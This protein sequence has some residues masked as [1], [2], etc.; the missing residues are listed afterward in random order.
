MRTG[1]RPESPSTSPPARWRWP[2]GGMYSSPRRCS[3]ALH[4]AREIASRE[5][6]SDKSPAST[7]DR[8][9]RKYQRIAAQARRVRCAANQS[10]DDS[11]STSWAGEL[12]KREPPDGRPRQAQ[13]PEQ[14]AGRRNRSEE[15]TSELQ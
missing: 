1:N 12:R 5:A 15:H 3:G 2:A 4:S 14:A 13:E 8:K 11:P 9:T 7:V 10:S 6:L